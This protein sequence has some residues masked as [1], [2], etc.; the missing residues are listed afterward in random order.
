V[1]FTRGLSKNTGQLLASKD[2]YWEKNHVEAMVDMSKRG[3]Q[4]RG[5]RITSNTPGKGGDFMNEKSEPLKINGKL[6]GFINLKT[7]SIRW[8][9]SHLQDPRTSGIT[10]NLE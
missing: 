2:Q 1:G 7:K 4:S 9:R 8:T 3:E 6:L 10:Q 5:D